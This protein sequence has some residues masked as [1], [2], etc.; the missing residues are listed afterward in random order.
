M[1]AT[2]A[3]LNATADTT[4]TAA[5]YGRLPL[6][7]EPNQGQVTDTVQF[8]AHGPGYS[9]Y[10][11]GTDATLTLR[12]PRAPRPHNH[13]PRA[14][15][16][17]GMIEPGALTQTAP[18]TAAVLRL[19]YAGAN[20]NPQPTGEE[21]LPGVANYMVGGDSTRWLTGVPTYARVSYK[22]VYPGVDLVYYGTQGRLE[23]DWQV[24]PGADPGVIALA[25]DGARGL[26]LDGQGN[27]LLRTDAGVLVQ[28]APVVYQDSD[29]H[30]QRVSASYIV[31]R[32]RGQLR[33]RLLRHQPATGDRPGAGLRHLPGRHKL[34]QWRR[35]RRG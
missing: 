20:L 27:L 10:L 5:A 25:I 3:T 34:R 28:R 26:S 1:T 35:H 24:A 14:G 21:R 7:F 29:G 11:R 8:L 15:A 32:R 19:R 12:A 18:V 6:S 17:A 9:L 31:D 30:R 2:V 23:Y 13:D 4:A 16:G 22:N 33:A